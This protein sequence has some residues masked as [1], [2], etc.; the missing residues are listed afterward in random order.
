[1]LFL[2]R[3]FRP[4]PARA[5]ALALCLLGTIPSLGLAAEDVAWRAAHEAIREAGGWKAYLRESAQAQEALRAERQA[6]EE[7]LITWDFDQ[8]IGLAFSRQPGLVTSQERWRAL[9][10]AV[11]DPARLSR[12]ARIVVEVQTLALQWAHAREAFEVWVER[13]DLA[14]VQLELGRRMQAVGNLPQ[15]KLLAL[16]LSHLQMRSHRLAAQSRARSAEAA[17][18]RFWLQY[19]RQQP[20]LDQHRFS[21]RLP[22]G[23]ASFDTGGEGGACPRA[24]WIDEPGSRAMFD[25]ARAADGRG[26]LELTLAY[27]R[28]LETEALWRHA[29]EQAVLLQQELWPR[30]Q[31]LFDEQLLQY[32]GMFIGS[33]KLLEERQHLLA[34]ALRVLD[35]QRDYG[36]A[37]ARLCHQQILV[38]LEEIP[39]SSGVLR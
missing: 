38:L 18:E 9:R 7:R 26:P 32:N 28:L 10:Q 17:L 13:E 19:A 35:A 31:A 4:R 37:Q 15:R 23:Q 3:F 39:F 22:A 20:R 21:L 34:T 11:H 25:R 6:R 12:A 16:E 5:P 1:M 33:P 36:L 30:Q 8:L 24:A 29:R 27:S 14:E 2:N